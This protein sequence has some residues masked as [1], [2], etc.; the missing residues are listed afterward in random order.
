MRNADTKANG[1]ITNTILNMNIF[2]KEE[3]KEVKIPLRIE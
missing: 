2:K 3:N 1:N